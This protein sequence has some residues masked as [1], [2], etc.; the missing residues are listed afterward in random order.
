MSDAIELLLKTTRDALAKRRLVI[1]RQSLDRM[2]GHDAAKIA[3]RIAAAE[4]DTENI[5]AS[6]LSDQTIHALVK[7][8]G[9]RH[10]NGLLIFPVVAP[11]KDNGAKKRRKSSVAESLKK[12]EEELAAEKLKQSLHILEDSQSDDD[13]DAVD[14]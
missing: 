1:E 3:D 2:L 11:K 10:A 7:C 12:A 14:D 9:W 5:S 8:D 4:Y 13:L 6:G